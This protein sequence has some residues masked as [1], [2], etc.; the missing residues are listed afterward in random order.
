[1]SSIF[2]I[3]FPN[4]KPQQRELEQPSELE[5]LK[6]ELENLK[7]S[8]EALVN[9]VDDLESQLE[10]K[11]SYD[12]YSELEDR[13]DSLSSIVSDSELE[14][15]NVSELSSRLDDFDGYRM[16]DLE[17]RIDGLENKESSDSSDRIDLLEKFAF[18]TESSLQAM[19]SSNPLGYELGIAFLT[20]S[21]AH[22]APMASMPLAQ[23]ESLKAEWIKRSHQETETETETETQAQA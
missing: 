6:A 2:D 13:I 22:G 9:R 3:L 1:M 17:S 15:V 12:Q 14:Y 8:N 23:L 19:F 10:D 21:L 5:S 18:V 20:N 4:R 7:A 16:S 11:A